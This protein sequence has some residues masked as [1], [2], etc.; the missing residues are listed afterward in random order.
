MYLNHPEIKPEGVA[1]D[2]SGLYTGTPVV[3]AGFSEA[4]AAGLADGAYR[5]RARSV[6]GTGATSGWI[7]PG[8]GPGPDF[9]VE[10]RA[11]A[12]PP[13]FLEGNGDEDDDL[14]GLLGAEFLLLLLVRLRR[15]KPISPRRRAGTGP[16]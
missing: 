4:V 7:A 1:F 6:D 13:G 11:P 3:G 16:R 5:W 12:P 15:P 14:C 8:A 10:R 9:R 2:G